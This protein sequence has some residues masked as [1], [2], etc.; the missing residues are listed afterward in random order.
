MKKILRKRVQHTNTSSMSGGS[1]TSLFYRARG[2][3]RLWAKILGAR[4]GAP[5]FLLGLSF[6]ERFGNVAFNFWSLSRPLS[7]FSPLLEATDRSGQDFPV[8]GQL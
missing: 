2:G 1:T 3:R 4:G 5:V 6:E 8:V 7:W